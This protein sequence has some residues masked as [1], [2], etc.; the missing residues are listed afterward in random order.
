MKNRAELEAEVTAL[1]AMVKALTG[2]HDIRALAEEKLWVRRFAGLA[3]AGLAAQCDEPTKMVAD[4]AAA[5]AH[6]AYHAVEARFDERGDS[7]Q[8]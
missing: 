7:E 8:A 2:D 3:L 6:L 1:R 5:W 4:Q